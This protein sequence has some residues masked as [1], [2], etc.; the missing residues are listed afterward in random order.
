MRSLAKAL[1]PPALRARLRGA[2][3]SFG[4]YRGP[5]LM[6]NIRKRWVVLRNPQADIRFGAHTFCGPG[7]KLHAPNGGTFV[8]GERVELRRDFRAELGGPDSRL[9]IGSGSYLTYSVLIQCG[10]TI[11]IG[12]RV[13]IGH[14]TSLYDGGHRY[15]DHQTPLLEQGYDYRPLLIEDDATVL[16]LCTVVNSIGRKAMVGANSI[17]TRPVPA[18]TLAAGTPARVIDYFGPPGQDPREQRAADNGASAPAAEDVK[19]PSP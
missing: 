13:G 10:T 14:C 9:E 15:R 17:V 6:S 16:G 18:Y 12:E 3:V 11:T 2:A 5:I 8:T 7:F 1:L 4:Y 19:P